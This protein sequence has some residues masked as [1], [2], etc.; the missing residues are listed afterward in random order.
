MDGGTVG[1][2]Q[3]HHHADGLQDRKEVIQPRAFIE[4]IHAIDQWL[5]V[6]AACDPGIVAPSDLLTPPLRQVLCARVV[7]LPYSPPSSLVG[8]PAPEES[9]RLIKVLAYVGTSA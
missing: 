4:P 9:G 6:Q 8:L 7:R 2:L 5:T 3:Q 1:L